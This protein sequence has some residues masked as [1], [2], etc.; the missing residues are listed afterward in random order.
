MITALIVFVSVKE[1]AQ[2]YP[3]TVD[4]ALWEKFTQTF[5]SNFASNDGIALFD[6][7]EIVPN[8]H[9]EKI[10]STIA[11]TDDSAV[12]QLDVDKLGSMAVNH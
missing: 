9:V 3:G 12:C 7:V 11:S 2:E 6:R 1:P 8:Q 5:R 4:E 10:Y